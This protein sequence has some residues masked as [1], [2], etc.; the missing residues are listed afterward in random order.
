MIVRS[1]VSSLE[2]ESAKISGHYRDTPDRACGDQPG[3]TLAAA[4]AR[5]QF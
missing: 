5:E 4:V 3:N 1:A 2:V